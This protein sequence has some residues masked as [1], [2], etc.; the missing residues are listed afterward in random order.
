[1]KI[2]NLIIGGAGYTGSLLVKKLLEMN[3]LVTVIDN[4]IYN[5]DSLETLKNNENLKIINADILNYTNLKNIIND[6]HFIYPLS[7]LVGDPVCKLDK[8]KTLINNIDSLKRVLEHIKFKKNKVIYPSSCSVYGLVEKPVS[9]TGLLNPQSLYAETKIECEN[10][11]KNL[12]KKNIIILR[13]P[14]IYGT[15]LRPRFDLVVNKMTLD[16]IKTN[17]VSV[18]NSQSMRPLLSTEDLANIYRI[19]QTIS[20]KNKTYN[21]GSDN[22]NLSMEQIAR[23][24]VKCLNDKV[25]KTSIEFHDE[26]DDPRSY[27][28]ILKRFNRDFS[29]K[30]FYSVESQVLKMFEF[31][32]KN[33]IGRFYTSKKYNNFH[34][35]W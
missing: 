30:S 27:S 32:N 24:I 8:N 18:F 22:N 28:I 33:K 1:M 3:Q 34:L 16:L 17:K 10:I 15:S 25:K 26:V 5:K 2:N 31:I 9:E 19:C 29:Y 12:D 7:G 4:F 35:K 13:L 21:I 23:R 11:L 6:F 14:T 20:N